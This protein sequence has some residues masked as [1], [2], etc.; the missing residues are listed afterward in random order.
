M[1]IALDTGN[2]NIVL[3]I[4][5]H[6]QVL[7]SA[8]FAT[9]RGKTEDEYA[10]FFKNILELHGITSED[11]DGGI[12]ASVVPPLTH[13]LQRAVEMV[14]G[15]TPLIVG[16]GVKT[17]LNILID[18]PKQLGSD[19]VVDAIAAMHDYEGPLI[20]LDV[21]TATTMSVVDGKG[22]YLGSVIIPGIRISQEALTSRTSQLPRISLE[23]PSRVIGKNTIE[24]M[25]SGLVFGQ[26]S[27]LD[28]M[29]DRIEAE[30]GLTTTVVAT[31]GLARIIIP[32]CHHKIIYDDDLLIKGL[33]IIYKKNAK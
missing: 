24:A 22:S 28:G 20:I 19:M 27:L 18:N 29:I 5:D 33:M 21:G 13:V 17:G 11:L 23:S 30:L 4:I 26:A 14:S 32:H 8:R 7:F 31:G 12:I 16:P 1:I 2:T 3:G 6:D 10:V 9:D 15:I 25:Q